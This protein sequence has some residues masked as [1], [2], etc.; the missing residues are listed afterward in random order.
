[1]SDSGGRN[2]AKLEQNTATSR[3][4]NLQ[5]ISKSMGKYTTNL[6]I[7]DDKCGNQ[8]SG[9]VVEDF[10]GSPDCGCASTLLLVEET[11]SE[12]PWTTS[13]GSGG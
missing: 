12:K 7:T 10:L 8:C 3:N 4:V 2:H 5:N 1:L 11:P 6:G 13:G 9:Q